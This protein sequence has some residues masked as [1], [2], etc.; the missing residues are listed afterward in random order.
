MSALPQRARASITASHP[1][2]A[3]LNTD[4]DLVAVLVEQDQRRLI[5][6]RD[7]AAGTRI[8]T[9]RGRET[10]IPTRY[11]VQ[12]SRDTHLDP[13]DVPTPIDRVRQRQWMYLN[14]HCAP[15]AW[16][17]E[18]VLIALRNIPTGDGVTFDYNTT[19]WDMASPFDCHCGSA[20][21]VGRV[22]GAK[23]LSAAQR[24]RIEP[25]LAPYFPAP[26]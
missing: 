10:A 7:I 13:D 11:S 6:V 14:H 3:V 15:N 26:A 16:I 5:A 9:L 18:R 22:R 23:H 17:T 2:G 25:W 8:I 19:E 4:C 1:V 21:C 24:A 12:V 20:E